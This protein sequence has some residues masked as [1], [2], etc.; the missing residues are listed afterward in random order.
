MNLYISCLLLLFTPLFYPAAGPAKTASAVVLI[1]YNPAYYISD[2]DNEIAARSDL[3]TEK[4]KMMFR[5]ELDFALEGALAKYQPARN[6][7]MDTIPQARFDIDSL[8]SIM[9]YGMKKTERVKTASSANNPLARLNRKD[10]S[11][12]E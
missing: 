9:N 4:L 11:R 10:A 8:Y 5:D 3:K 7:L 6:L 2:S 1:P 12:D